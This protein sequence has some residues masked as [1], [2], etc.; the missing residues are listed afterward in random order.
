[1]DQATVARMLAR[2][3]DLMELRGENAFRVRAYREGARSIAALPDDLHA[4]WR[5]GQLEQ[6]PG[7][8]PSLSA[9]I[10]ELLRTGQLQLLQDLEHSLPHGILELTRVPGLGPHRARLIAEALHVTSV[11][12]LIRAA[13]EHRL[14]TLPGLGARSE[15][16]LLLEARRLDT[17]TR[18]LPLHVAWPLA[19]ALA[20]RLRNHRAVEQ[21]T[22]AG[23]IRRR[24]ETVGDVDLLVAS[25]RPEQVFDHLVG[26][27]EVREVLSRGPTKTSVLT[28]AG[29]QVDVRV[30]PPDTWGAALQY[31]T[32]SRAHNVHLRQRAIERGLKISEYGL[33]EVKSG[34]RL[35]GATEAEVYAAL[36]LDWIPPELREDRGELQAAERHALPALVRLEDIRGDT[37]AHTTWSDGRDT[38]AAMG[39]RAREL[40]YQWLVISDHSYGLA[41]AH[42]LSMERARAQRAELEALNRELAP[43]RLL[44]GIEL[45]IRGDGTLD[46]TDE[47]LQGFDLVAASLHLG[48]R[49]GARNNTVRLTAALN[50]AE[51]D[52]LNHPTG[53]IVG[54]RAPYEVDLGAVLRAAQ[55]AGKPVEI[56][57]SERMDLG[58]EAARHAA[59]LGLRFTLSTDAHAASR[60]A[61]MRYAVA[62]ARRA[63]LT[64]PQVLNT[65]GAADFL[66]ALH[67][68]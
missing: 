16:Q 39:R 7:I 56:N 51:V 27:T 60:L 11:P 20:D 24:L 46:F 67:P 48:T 6:V 59:E 52:A 63:R 29:V 21:V 3:A 47:E 17:R 65:L 5:A 43:F 19:D 45:E 55:R 18:R 66:A 2:A 38:M 35:A 34:R 53:R 14:R 37:H 68:R 1:M 36:E 30:V 32:G 31:F 4:R 57:G 58:D 40:G 10:D 61:D 23:S 12:E 28:E 49:Q 64:A 62:I 9:R 22:P 44:Q 54:E 50:D 42:G 13:E 26:L 25:S 15:E 41:V 33:F 8:G